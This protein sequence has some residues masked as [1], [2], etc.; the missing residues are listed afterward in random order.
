MLSKKV[1]RPRP[2]VPIV[3]EVQYPS[4]PDQSSAVFVALVQAVFPQWATLR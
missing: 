2:S 4:F 3:I 1:I